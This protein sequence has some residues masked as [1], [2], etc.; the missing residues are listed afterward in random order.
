MAAAVHHTLV[1]CTS[2][3]YDMFNSDPS[4]QRFI[5]DEINTYSYGNG[6]QCGAHWLSIPADTQGLFNYKSKAEKTY[7]NYS[8]EKRKHTQ[9]LEDCP[10]AFVQQF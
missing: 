6:Y 3:E 2:T 10:P 9:S 4:S 1:N 7:Q 5:E 8:V